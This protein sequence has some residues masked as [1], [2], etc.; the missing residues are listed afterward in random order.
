MKKF[1]F[2]LVALYLAAGLMADVTRIVA[3]RNGTQIADR[4]PY[5]DIFYQ[6]NFEGGAAG[7][8]HWDGAVSPNNWHIYANGD[9]QGDVWWM[10]DPAL[11][12][13]SNIGGYYDQQYLVLDTPAQTIQAGNT[14]LSFKMRLNVEAPGTS[15]DYNGWDSFNIRISTNAGITYTVIPTDLLSVPYD[16][17]SSYAFG[18]QHGEG[19][20]VPAW[21]GVHEPWQSVVVNLAGFVGQS[22]KIRFAFASDPAFSTADDPTMFGAMVDDIAFGGYSNNGVNDTQMS[23]TSLVPTAGDFWH[24]AT[25]GNDAPSPTHIMSCRNSANTYVNGMYNFLMSPTINLPADATQIVADFQLRG[26]YTDPGVFPDVD[27]FGWEISVNNGPW[28]YMSNITQDPEGNN[29][30]YSGA[31]STWMSMILSYTLDGD[32]TIFAGQPVKFRWYFQSNNTDP[33][34]FPLELDDFQIFS[35]SAAPAAP[36]L[37]FP[38][39]GADNVPSSGFSLDWSASSQGAL[40]SYYTIYMDTV[41][42]NLPSEASFSWESSTSITDPVVNGGVTFTPGQRWYWQV[43]ASILDQPEALS[44]IYRFDITNDVVIN[45]F[46]W[47][48]DFDDLARVFPPTGWTIADLDGGGT[49]WTENTVATYNHTPGGTKSAKHGY[50]PV[51][52]SSNGWLI[53]PAVSIPF[54]TG[55]L[56]YLDWWNYNVYPTY[57]VYNG[58]LVNPVSNDPNDGN[59]LQIWSQGTAT[60]AWTNAAV[61]I[62]DYAGQIVYFAFNYQGADADDWYV[63]DVHIIG[64][65]ED[66]YAPVITHLP[67]L[68]SLRDDIPYT[69]VAD[70][71]D[72]AIWNNDIASANLYYSTDGGTTW[73]PP[74]AMAADVR[75]AW[76][77]DI[78]AQVIG[79][80]VTYYMDATDSEGN[81]ATSLSYSFQVNDPVWIQYDI[82]GTGYTGY[83]TYVWGPMIYYENP[84]YGTGN[85]LHL[86]AVDGAVH[87]SSTGNP[88]AVANLHVYADD[89]VNL[90]D[91]I[92]PLPVTFIHRTRLETDLSALNIQITSPYFWISY[93]DLPLG[94]YFRYD[95]TYDY[96]TLYL[97][98]SGDGI[99]YSSSPGEWAIGAYV[100]THEIEVAT[101]F[102]GTAMGITWPAV[103][104]ATSYNVY[105]S[106]DPYAPDPWTLLGNVT[107]P[108][109]SYTVS[110]PMKFIKVTAVTPAPVRGIQPSRTMVQAPSITP[111]MDRSMDIL[112]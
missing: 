32:I 84:L 93:E 87:N 7:W 98:I 61:N 77:A 110:E 47:L 59:W 109:Y 40:P 5:R 106:N 17:T 27:Y 92:T 67:V 54:I 34:G 48:E 99:Y 57:M 56:W 33:I 70:I 100:E 37:I 68:N 52:P 86:L 71:V 85:P 82:G 29:Y 4:Y 26:S 55:A 69:V 51:D 12:S 72:D 24:L 45:T 81:T 19:P 14:T 41:E 42:A 31:A 91:L 90:T 74:I 89:G 107:T 11:A 66:E 80:T 15:G 36:N 1:L 16:F 43:G 64:L 75:D 111:I 30:V 95:A 22:V 96:T 46:P 18:E 21:G 23:W 76:S 79:T 101:T 97:M 25:V 50:G 65:T 20:G 112:N 102:D 88:P 38:V 9:A 60:Q 78:P 39:N 94:C 35:V 105:G 108:S 58:V 49:T 8:T 53:T 83:P 44:E 6:E 3:E 104:G 28:L 62:T 2:L 10:G 103:A 13:G 73:N 63:D